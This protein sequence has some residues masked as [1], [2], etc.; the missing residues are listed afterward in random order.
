MAKEKRSTQAKVAPEIADK[1]YRS[2]KDTFYHGV[3][4]HAVAQQRPGTMPLPDRVGL[5]SGSEN[6]LTTLR[7]VLPALQGGQ[8]YGDKAY[9]DSSLRDRLSEELWLG[10][11]HTTEEIERTG[12]ALSR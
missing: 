1:G 6:D 7:Q 4:L 10:A 8:L 2:S 9:V 12:A 11:S 5:S 3:K